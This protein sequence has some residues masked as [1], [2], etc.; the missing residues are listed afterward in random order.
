MGIK[1]CPLHRLPDVTWEVADYQASAVH[2]TY[3]V[4][5]RGASCTPASAALSVGPE[6]HTCSRPTSYTAKVALP[7]LATSIAY[8]P[9]MAARHCSIML[10]PQL[11][12][13]GEPHTVCISTRPC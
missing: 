7:A 12:V 11:A 4:R 10:Q 8:H 1:R 2:F 6:L 9:C 5:G 13:H 3:D